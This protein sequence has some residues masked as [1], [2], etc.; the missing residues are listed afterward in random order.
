[1]TKGLKPGNEA[2][3]SGIYRQNPGNNEVTV[4]RGE[5]LPPGPKGSHPTYTL[6]REARHKG[7]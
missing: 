4:D 5:K 3:K 1:M 7:K 2:P 6:I